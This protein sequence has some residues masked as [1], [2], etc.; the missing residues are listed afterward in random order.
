MIIPNKY[1]H[2]AY[3]HDK[4][5]QRGLDWDHVEHFLFLGPTGPQ[6]VSYWCMSYKWNGAHKSKVRLKLIVKDQYL[7]TEAKYKELIRKK[8]VKFEQKI[9]FEILKYGKITMRQRYDIIN[10]V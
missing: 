8:Q 3:W 2:V 9:M 6:K 10:S 1:D 5:W 7:V 4:S